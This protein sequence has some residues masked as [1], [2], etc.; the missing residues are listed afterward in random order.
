MV[1]KIVFLIAI[2]LI[3]RGYAEDTNPIFDPCSDTKV[4]KLDGFS[5]GLAFSTRD[6]FFSNQ[7]QLSPCDRRLSL[8]GNGSSSSAKLAVFRPKVDEISLLT[9]D[10]SSFNP[11]ML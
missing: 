11:G 1:V 10:S 8:S 9:I 5:F 6:S 2:I 4:Q 3:A 7:T